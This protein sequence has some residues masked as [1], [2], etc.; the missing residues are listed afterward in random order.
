MKITRRDIQS[1][2]NNYPLGQL[3][4][5]SLPK[6]GLL[7][8]VVLIKTTKGTYILKATAIN[9]D[10]LDEVLSLLHSIKMKQTPTLVATNQK[11]LSLEYKN[12]RVFIYALIPGRV[13][14][15]VMA[16]MPAEIGKFLGRYHL[17][18]KNFRVST[19][20]EKI[21]DKSPVSIKRAIILAQLVKTNKGKSAL[22]HIKKTINRYKLIS[23][24]PVGPIHVDI[25]P[26]NSLFIGRKLRGVIDFDNVYQGPLI[27]DL[28]VAMSWYGVSMAQI[29]M[30]HIKELYGAYVK[31]RSLNNLEKRFLW[32]A[33]HFA[34]L[35]NALRAL[36]FLAQGRLPQKW[37]HDYLDCYLAA[38]QKFSLNEKEFIKYL[39]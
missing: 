39:V 19:K 9:T 18:I 32:N 17:R 23:S 25:K 26:D 6:Q 28:A 21:L 10:T 1:I 4:N 34:I 3:K 14:K 38:E 13:P 35:R 16:G 8:K 5:Y 2:L 30:S 36:E 33:F 11:K 22:A 7:N 37:V 12:Y 24:L 29:N 27:L 20:R 31:K 15:K